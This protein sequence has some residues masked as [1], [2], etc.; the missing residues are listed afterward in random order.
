M[1]A[2][3]AIQSGQRQTGSLKALVLQFLLMAM[4][5]GLTMSAFGI[6]LVRGT[7]GTPDLMLIKLGVSLFMLISGMCMIVIAKSTAVR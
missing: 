7:Y 4:G 2:A 6:W 1:H 5:F 3:E